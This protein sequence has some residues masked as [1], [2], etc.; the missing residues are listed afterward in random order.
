MLRIAAWSVRGLVDGRTGGGEAERTYINAAAEIREA[1]I[2]TV[3]KLRTYFSTRNMFISDN[4]LFKEK[5]LGF[6]WDRATSHTER[7]PS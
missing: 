5:F 6:Q 2:K 1:R 3:D 4:Q 7:G